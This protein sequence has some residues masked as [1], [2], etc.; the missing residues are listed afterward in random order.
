[1]VGITISS[2]IIIGCG[3]SSKSVCLRVDTQDCPN[4]QDAVL[5]L[6]QYATKNMYYNPMDG[7]Y[8][9]EKDVYHSIPMPI[10]GVNPTRILFSA[11]GDEVDGP[12]R[13]HGWEI[14][15]GFWSRDS[16]RCYTY[17]EMFKWKYNREPTQAELDALTCEQVTAWFKKRHT[18]KRPWPL[19]DDPP[20]HVKCYQDKYK[21]YCVKL[22]SDAY[23]YTGHI[24]FRD[25]TSCKIIGFQI[26]KEDCDYSEKIIEL[27]KP[28]AGCGNN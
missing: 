27:E 4:S 6:E 16:Y 12:N 17:A 1:M 23:R 10:E 19:S 24:S 22:N 25:G 14:N 20:N 28:C 15:Y 13:I 5:S 18:V 8:A 9:L 3:E 11:S 26:V 21:K 2:K 7:S